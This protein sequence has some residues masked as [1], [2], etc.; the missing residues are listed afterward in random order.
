M[1]LAITSYIHNK[2][3][4][5]LSAFFEN[6]FGGFRKNTYLCN[7][8]GNEKMNTNYTLTDYI[9]L[10]MLMSDEPMVKNV[11][12]SDNQSAFQHLAHAIT[13]FN[14]EAYGN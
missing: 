3:G 11:V 12:D 14:R 1:S 5:Q 4:T 10:M 6:K 2:I 9:K 13:D 8:K 7:T